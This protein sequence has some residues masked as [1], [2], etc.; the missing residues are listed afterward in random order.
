MTDVKH[1]FSE[2]DLQVC[3]TIR[4]GVGSVTSIEG[5]GTIILSCKNGDHWALTGVYYI[6]HLKM[7]II[8]IG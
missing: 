1:F 5:R 7:S 6:P 3:R 2:L 8:S 4:F